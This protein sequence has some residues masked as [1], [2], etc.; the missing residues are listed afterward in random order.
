[1]IWVS[2]WQ[3]RLGLDWASAVAKMG[4][5]VGLLGH[6]GSWRFVSLTLFYLIGIDLSQLFEC[7]EQSLKILFHLPIADVRH[8]GWLDHDSYA[9]SFE[10][11]NYTF[12]WECLDWV[13]T[14]ERVEV[15]RIKHVNADN[16]DD[17]SDRKDVGWHP[18]YV[19]LQK[20]IICYLLRLR[21]NL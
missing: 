18:Q 3:I 17:S 12:H 1:M 6:I 9:I 7:R 15:Y 13:L 19:Q 5:F 11:A 2:S 10:V 21:I 14:Q 4:R 20:H 8:A 16:E